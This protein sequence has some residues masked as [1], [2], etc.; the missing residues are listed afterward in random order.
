MRLFKA[1]EV[2]T[3]YHH[4]HEVQY[5]TWT[6]KFSSG[7]F[8]ASAETIASMGL[9]SEGTSTVPQREHS[10]AIALPVCLRGI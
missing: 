3:K 4:M 1:N 8:C 9:A 2:K 7:T 10:L 5:L 6:L